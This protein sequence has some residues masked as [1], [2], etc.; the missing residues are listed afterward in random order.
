M[1]DPER[2][3][4]GSDGTEGRQQ[5]SPTPPPPPGQPTPQQPPMPYAGA[6]VPPPYGQPAPQ[7][8][9]YPGYGQPPYPQQPY[10]AYP[11]PPY[12]QAPQK[13]K[14]KVWPWVLGGCLLVFVLGVGG[15]VGC[16][17]CSMIY[18]RAHSYNSLDSYYNPYEDYDGS[19]GYHDRYGYPDSSDG[20]GSNDSSAFGTF[21]RQEIENS[22]GEAL[23]ST[24][25]DGRC[26]SGVYEVGSG[27]DIEPGRY[28]FE[29]AQAAE[30]DFYVFDGEGPDAFKLDDAVVY[31]GNYFAD[32]ETGDLVVFLGAEDSLRMYPA[33]TADFKAEAPY[34][35][36]LYRVGTDL[37]AGTY[38]ISVSDQAEGAAQSEIAAFVMK[39][40]EFDDDSITDAKY[41]IRGGSQTV[42][43]KDGDW[44]ELYGT[45]ATPAQ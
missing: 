26:S 20:F 7:Q 39:N 17:S 15:C 41:V 28:F 8:P 1:N 16:M 12:P 43:V 4:P 31:F 37:P 9:P 21:S 14:R 6:P 36:G 44:L 45:V 3:A 22:I 5:S 23:P 42:T 38:A 32:L 24:I 40:L 27:K 10:G 35:S 2:P 33:A 29:G 25:E 19:G 30:S 13:P 34:Q 18:D 11:P